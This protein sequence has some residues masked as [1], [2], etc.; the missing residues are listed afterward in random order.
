MLNLT[1][2]DPHGAYQKML[3]A[4]VLEPGKLKQQ[5]ID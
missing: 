3:T 4:V 5:P 1:I 2:I